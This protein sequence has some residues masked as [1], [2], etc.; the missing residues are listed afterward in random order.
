[1]IPEIEIIRKIYILTRK[2]LKMTP[3]SEIDENLH[4]YISYIR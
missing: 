4:N 2:S 1:M 3:V